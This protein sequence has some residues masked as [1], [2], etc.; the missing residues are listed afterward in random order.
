MQATGWQN[1]PPFLARMLVAGG[2]L[3]WGGLAVDQVHQDPPILQLFDSTCVGCCI[4][5]SLSNRFSLQY[6]FGNAA[7]WEDALIALLMQ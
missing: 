4:G 5:A 3:G 2:G 7:C 6:E 1:E